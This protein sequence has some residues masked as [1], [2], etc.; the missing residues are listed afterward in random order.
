MILIFYYFFDVS[1][2][3]DWSVIHKCDIFI[4][5][6]FL[7]VCLLVEFLYCVGFTS[8]CVLCFVEGK[9]FCF[10]DALVYAVFVHF[11]IKLFVGFIENISLGIISMNS[12]E[13]K[14]VSFDVI[15][16]IL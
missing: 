16:N 5:Q 15:V 1:Y 11:M 9:V 8:L 4:F 7:P 10:Y 14:F 13:T 2:L 12:E 3:F 6:D